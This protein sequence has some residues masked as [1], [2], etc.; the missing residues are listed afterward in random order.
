MAKRVLALVVPAALALAGC[1]DTWGER[2]ASGG[3]IGLASGAAA[4]ALIGG[5]P[6]WGGAL[7]GVAAGAAI[8]AI[9]T[10]DASVTSSSD[11]K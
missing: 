10:P 7:I 9:T 3:A 2:A 5:L 6:I 8:G 4:G 11:G 1:G